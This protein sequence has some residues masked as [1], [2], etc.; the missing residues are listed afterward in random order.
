MRIDLFYTPGCQKCVANKEGLRAT[1]KKLIQH[2]LMSPP[3]LTALDKT[4]PPKLA[5]EG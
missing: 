3:S 5:A 2:Q 4:C 1:A